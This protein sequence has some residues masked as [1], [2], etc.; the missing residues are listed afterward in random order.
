M[1]KLEGKVALV[2]GAGRGI[3]RAIALA[4]GGE[5]AKVA[6]A[7]RTGATVDGLVAEI[8]AAGGT[9][10]GI[11]CDVTQR[12]QVFAAVEQTVATF[13]TLEILVNN[14][15]SFGRE[16]DPKTAQDY[17]PLQEVDEAVLEYTFRSAF[18][19]TWWAM[20]A[21]FPYLSKQGGKVINFGSPQAQINLE[22]G[23]AYNM[24]KEAVRSLS[25]T[26]AREWGPLNI[27][28]NVINPMIL[29]DA[30]S[31]AYESAPTSFD[32]TLAQVPLRRFG[33]PHRDLAPVAVFLASRDS[34]Y[35]TGQ[36]FQVD[37][38]FISRP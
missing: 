37:G 25:R 27:Q 15:Q 1:G 12:E 19:A 35:M 26:A 8:T 18:M 13:G 31:E 2:T 20:T 38:G 32:G 23:I 9:A 24:T 5:G 4:Y 29:T 36:T 14:A 34:D 30:L 7:S 17:R 28:V 22:G 16:G 10:L 11:C 33:D 21:A 6:V 3:G